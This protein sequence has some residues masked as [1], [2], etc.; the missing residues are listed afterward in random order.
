MWF[1]FNSKGGHIM[2]KAKNII[3][4]RAVALLCAIIALAALL[5]S[6]N[7]TRTEELEINVSVLN[8][9]T[10]FGAA[11]LMSDA[12]NG[13]A[14]LNYKFTVEKDP[15]PITKGLINGSIDIAMLPTNA[16]ATLYNKTN[17][18]IRIAAVNTLGVLYLIV[19]GDNVSVTDISE[20]EGKTVYCPAQNPAFIFEA[21][22][23]ASGLVPGESITI[24]TSYAKPEE[25]RTAIV[26]GLVDIAVLPEPMVTIAKSANASLTTALDLTE[27]WEAIYPGTIMQGCVV[28]RTEWAEAHPKEL[29]EFL[30]EY[31]NSV[32]F[33]TTN[34]AEASVMIAELGIF[35]QAK[36]AEKAIPSCNIEFIDGKEM[37]EGL[38]FFY[39]KLF[40]V[41]P[42]A[43][44]GK[45]PDETIYYVRQIQEK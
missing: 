7:V 25:L 32:V 41:N 12:K 2:K 8:G 43:V 40:A 29:E 19:N 30:V 33:T 22:C 45:L 42:A 34:P 31:Q 36:V 10:G 15:E 39:E 37:S 17:G 27:I 18:G 11:K 6:C 26:S 21:V 9:T 14:A 1:E 16:A 44:G 28:V 20:L 4:P 24:D 35:A 23:R 3:S 13:Q 5:C 38:A